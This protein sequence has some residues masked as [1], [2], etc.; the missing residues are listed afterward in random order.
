MKP[1][2]PGF[3]GPRLK[4]AREARFLSAIALADLLGVSR[5]AVSLYENGIKT[6]GPEVM[7]SLTRILNL[8]EIFFCR[9]LSDADRDDAVFWRSMSAATKTA[10]SRAKMRYRWIREIVYYLR[11]FIAFPSVNL[12][13]LTLPTNPYSILFDDIEEYATLTRK[14]WNLGSGPI[15]NLVWILENNGVIV[16]RDTLGADTL[17]SLSE[18]RQDDG[19]PYMV[20]GADKAVCARS[21]YD[22]AHELGHLILH[23]EFDRA[24]LSSLPVFRLIEDQANRFAA[25]FLIP[26]STFATDFYSANLDVLA[27]LKAKWRVSIA[28]MIK[29]ASDLS[30]ISPDHE[31]RLWINFSRRHWRGPGR[32]PMDDKLEVEQPKFLCRSLQLLLKERIQTREQVLSRLPYDANDIEALTGLEPGSLASTVIVKEPPIRLLNVKGTDIH[33]ENKTKIISFPT[34]PKT[35]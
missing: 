11:E 7:Q 25:A 29:R 2:T 26:A 4:E 9:Q 27:R 13:N 19:I 12:P 22:A 20:L 6:P 1:G 3:V 10:R 17:D 30:F 34:R 21:R 33:K 31:K 5:Q 23:R 16:A 32:E 28:M 35:H 18:F 14:F 24:A 15:D 8:P